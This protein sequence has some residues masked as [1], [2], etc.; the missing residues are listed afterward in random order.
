MIPKFPHDNEVFL[1]K[2]LIKKWKQYVNFSN[3]LVKIFGLSK[4][5]TGF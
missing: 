3:N 5:T 1:M 4:T 2:A